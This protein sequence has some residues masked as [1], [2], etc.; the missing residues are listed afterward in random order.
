MNAWLFAGGVKVRNASMA[1]WLWRLGMLA[2]S[3]LIV[4]WVSAVVSALTSSHD[5]A[6][7]SVLALTT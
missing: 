5:S 7:Y 2:P 3:S 1:S 6:G 4:A